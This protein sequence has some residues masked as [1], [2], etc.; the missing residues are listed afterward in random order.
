MALLAE[1][2]A[3]PEEQLSLFDFDTLQ[4][5]KQKRM[6]HLS[7]ALDRLRERFGP[8]TFYWGS[9]R[10]AP[11]RAPRGK[12]RVLARPGWEGEMVPGRRHP[13]IQER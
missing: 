12:G 3:P 1:A 6:Q 2:L 8:H 9:T 5:Q 13:L 11:T 10:V 4:S 7:L